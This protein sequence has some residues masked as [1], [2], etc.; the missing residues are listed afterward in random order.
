MGSLIRF[1]VAALASPVAL[2]LTLPALLM[3]LPFWAVA[4]GQR[5]WVRLAGILGEQ[6]LSLDALVDYY[7]GVGWKPKPNLSASA[8]DQAGNPYSLTTDADGWRAS[9]HARGQADV[10]VFGDSFAFGFGTSDR[11]FFANVCASP[12]I[13]AIG[14]NGYNLVQELMLMEQH[15]ELLR[16][17]MVVWFVY[18]GNDLYENLT[19]NL[20]R[21]RMPFVRQIDD[22]G[23]WEIVSE[24]VSPKRWSLREDRDYYGK[25]A[26]IC[27]GTPLSS[28]AF[29][30]ARFLIR[31]G[32]RL[33]EEVDATLVVISLPDVLQLD[34]SRSHLLAK[35][36]SHPESFDVDRP[37][38]ALR[39]IC[40]QEEV[41]FASIK[42]FL[43]PSDYIYSDVHW[44][45]RGNRRVADLIR[46]LYAEPRRSS[47]IPE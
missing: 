36:A 17:A 20:G 29:G 30:A 26:E 14:A 47:A 8:L 21:Y 2:L 16:G 18:H 11:D 41:R 1:V 39:E 19:P 9:P 40:K 38:K 28:K 4:A 13:R 32:K 35:R 7:P 24:H 46:A 6:P 15:A 31:R 43:K 5:L 22:D 27:C 12:R 25:L 44:N 34:T 33:C 10:Y 37:D 3:A 45:A 23:D 42:G